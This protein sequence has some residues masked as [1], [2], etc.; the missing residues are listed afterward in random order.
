MNHITHT[1]TNLE[2]PGLDVLVVHE[3]R[4]YEEL[5]SQELVRKVYL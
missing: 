2:K 3:L 5:A 4:E 1:C